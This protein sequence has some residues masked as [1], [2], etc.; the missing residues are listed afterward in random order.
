MNL[1]VRVIAICFL[2]LLPFSL[3]S[4]AQDSA[5]NGCKINM[6]I[7][8]I[9]NHVKSSAMFAGFN[10]QFQSTY[11]NPY[12]DYGFE[13][14][15]CKKVFNQKFLFSCGIGWNSFRYQVLY[16]NF[17]NSDREFAS[18]NKFVEVNY[19]SVPL[20]FGWR[21]PISTNKNETFYIVGFESVLITQIFDNYPE[22]KFVYFSN[23]KEDRTVKSNTEY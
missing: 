12:I 7:V 11:F 1:K 22:Q 9:K 10:N 20:K 8:A 6:N 2:I 21:L 18:I 17:V 19:I 16:N 4:N 14:N 23:G 3:F 13:I 5:K 15:A